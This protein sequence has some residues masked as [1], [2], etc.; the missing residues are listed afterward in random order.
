MFKITDQISLNPSATL[1]INEKVAEM[2]AKGETVYHFGFGESRFAVHPKLQQAL[3]ENA[4]RKSYLSVQG[5]PQ[6][7]KAVARYYS[8]RLGIGASAEQ[9]M[10]TPGS[11]GMLFALQ[12]ALDADLILPTPSWVSYAPQAKLLGKQVFTVES[13]AKTEYEWTI[14]QLAAVVERIGNRPKLLILNSPSNP[15][16]RMF[17]AS[18]LASLAEFCRQQ[19]I[20]VISDEIYGLV[21]HGSQPHLSIAQYYPEGSA[22]LGGLSKHLSLGGWRLGHGILPAT[23]PQLMQAVIKIASEIWSCPTA[24]IQYAAL[25]AYSGDS[26]IEAYI[27]DCA[28]IHTAR[29]QHLWGWLRELGI[30]CP[31]PQGGFYL[32]PDFE[33]WREP[34]AKKGVTTSAELAAYLLEEHHIATL[35]TSVFGMP[36]EALSLRLATSYIDMEDDQAADRILSRWQ[37][38]RDEELLMVNDHPQMAA[39]IGE[40]QRFVGLLG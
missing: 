17:S 12:M 26:E 11:K 7:R 19:K 1:G 29:T 31:E 18:F 40:L 30:R 20:F 36:A 37:T 4:H 13:T 38:V 2:W 21:P 16:G 32:T 28:V 35:P 15:T 3:A 9:V 34:L 10:I 6:L 25:S 23:E 33:R 39:A 24:P 8:E 14:D 27:A 22:V 5:L